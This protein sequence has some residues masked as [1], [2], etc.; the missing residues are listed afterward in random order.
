MKK[1]VA[2]V[3]ASVIMLGG[4]GCSTNEINQEVDESEPSRFTIVEKARTW[5]IVVD[6]ETSVM[7]AVS[8]GSY[9][10]GTFTLLVDA[11]GNPLLYN[12]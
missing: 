10:Y 6:N 7:Y 1:I 5:L 9:N 12:E 8:N 2:M 11:D 4:V 3:L